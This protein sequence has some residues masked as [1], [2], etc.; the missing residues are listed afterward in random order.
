MES[1][2]F[3]AMCL[4]AGVKAAII[5]VVLVNRLE[6]DQVTLAKIDI[7]KFYYR[8]WNIALEYLKRNNKQENGGCN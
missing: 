8:P 2:V 1:T 3:S 5:C 4:R 6:T 7:E